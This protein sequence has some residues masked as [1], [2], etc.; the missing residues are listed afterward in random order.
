LTHRY[1]FLSNDIPGV[2]VCLLPKDGGP[3]G[4]Q[5][6]PVVEQ[7]VDVIAEE[8]AEADAEHRGYKEEEKNVELALTCNIQE[9]IKDAIKKH[10]YAKN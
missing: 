1:F 3:E 4:L 2:V 7:E 10:F 9:R 5:R 6:G 8:G